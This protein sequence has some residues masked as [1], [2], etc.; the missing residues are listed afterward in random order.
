MN[1]TSFDSYPALYVHAN[2]ASIDAQTLYFRLVAG[3]YISLITASVFASEFFRS[4]QSTILYAFFVVAGLFLMVARSMNKPEQRWYAARALAES[5]KT[6]TWRFMMRSEPFDMKFDH[7]TT[8]EAAA[9][10]EFQN[11]LLSIVRSNH[12]VGAKLAGIGSDGQQITTEMTAIRK[13]PLKERLALYHT[14]RVR[15]QRKWYAKRAAR[16]KRNF[17][18]S[19]AI[20]ISIYVVTILLIFEQIHSGSF[21][22]F[23]TEAFLLA[24]S[25]MIGW[26]QAKKYNE[27]ASSYTLTAHEI[28]IAEQNIEYITVESQLSAYVNNTELAFSRE[29]T[30]WVARTEL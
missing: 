26:T 30:Q 15:E 9:Q 20:G 4:D 6:A 23:P 18:I 1:S 3:E 5:V 13:L 22:S 29:H 12:F 8:T 19:L 27:L 11:Y 17:A 14:Q 10:S 24:A 16:H 21:R 25:A 7:E 28:G 2:M